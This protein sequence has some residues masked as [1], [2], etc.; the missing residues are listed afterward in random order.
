MIRPARVPCRR[1]VASAAWAIPALALLAATACGMLGAAPPAP[2]G[3]FVALPDRREEARVPVAPAGSVSVP[4]QVWAWGD[5]AF[6]QL[7]AG[8]PDWQGPRAIP[9]RVEQLGEVVSLAAGDD[10]SLAVTADGSVWAWG[11]N[12][13]GQLGD[14][15]RADRPTPVQVR[16]LR[17]V[18]VVRAGSR[19]SLALGRD[20]TVWAWGDNAA[21]QL[22][23][24][25]VNGSPLPLPVP[26][27]GRVA[28]VAAGGLQSLAL[29]ADGS[30]WSWGVRSPPEC[31]PRDRSAPAAPTRVAG[32]DHVA[33]IAAGTRHALAL[34]ADGRVYAWGDDDADQLD[35]AATA[36]ARCG[37]IRVSGLAG[38]RAVA[39]GGSHSLALLSDGTVWGWGSNLLGQRGALGSARDTP[40]TRVPGLDGVTAIAASGAHNVALRADGSVWTWGA[41][42]RSP[43]GRSIP[44]ASHHTPSRV[45]GVVGVTVIA[46]G[47]T[48][49]LALTSPPFYARVENTSPRIRYTGAWTTRSLAGACGGS[50]SV[51]QP[52]DGGEAALAWEGTDL[53]VLMPR[54]PRLGMAWIVVDEQDTY[55]VDLYSPTDQ[56]QQVVLQLAAL[57]AGPHLVVIA[58]S[59]QKNAYSGGTTIGLDAIDTR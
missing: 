44:I 33:A 39:A 54:G 30:V 40:L 52:L 38:I 14:G 45:P 57:P 6:G 19:H 11:D 28:D 50:V 15:T 18:A 29:T 37:P 26:G 12:T 5:D 59:S 51:T 23:T 4:G 13:F 20:G 42:T 48:H 2:G 17:G 1:P 7:G 3:A 53:A 21:G 31:R 32:L 9:A 55:L 35:G 16:G 58:P 22:G 41:L 47:P 27:L 25:S 8:A 34:T 10:H 46:V 49:A 43:S 24:A 56:Q 36:A